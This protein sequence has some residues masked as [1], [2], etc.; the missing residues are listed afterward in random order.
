MSD[1]EIIA[2]SVFIGLYTLVLLNVF[3]YFYAK[4]QPRRRIRK[5]YAD[6]RRR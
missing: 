1:V 5:S 2:M 6:Q 3:A 4:K